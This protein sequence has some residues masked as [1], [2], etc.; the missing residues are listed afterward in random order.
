MARNLDPK[1][2]QCRREG[3]KLFLRG[4]RC[5][6]PKCGMVKRNY[7]PGLHGVKRQSKPSGFGLQLREKQKAKKIYRMLEKQFR[8]NYEKAVQQKG[9]TG[10]ILMQLLERRFDNVVYRLGLAKS[11]D[12]ARQMISHSQ[13][14]V[15]GKPCNIPSRLMKVNDAISVKPNKITK[16]NWVNIQNGMQKVKVEVATWLSIDKKTLES[17]V[18]SLP[19]PA[20]LKQEID[21]YLI[22]EFYSR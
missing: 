5:L 9:D 13:F 16:T 12:M 4:E 19:T 10:E 22:V 18:I 7:P 2:K 21:P 14:R 17:K 20:D 15:N 3:V 11:R 6:S 1:C 8:N